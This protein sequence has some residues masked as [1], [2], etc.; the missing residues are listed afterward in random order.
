[1]PKTTK[2][3]RGALRIVEV[4]E[5]SIALTEFFGEEGKKQPKLKMTAY[6]G[7]VIK[8]HWY[9]DDLILDLQGVSFEKKFPILENHSTDRKIAF[10]SSPILENGKLEINPEKTKFVDTEISEEF[11]RLSSEG[12]PYQCSVYANP[13]VVERLS[14][15][16]TAEANGITLKG[17]GTIFRKWEMKEASVCVFGWDSKTQAT[18]FSKEE[19]EVD[20]DEVKIEAKIKPKLI[21]RNKGGDT[22]TIEELLKNNPELVKDIQLAAVKEAEIEFAKKE[23]K[24]TKENEDLKSENEKLND[25][26]LALEK[27]E[28]IREAKEL[29]NTADDIWTKKLSESDV[30]ENMHEKICQYVSYT[31]FTEDGILDVEKFGEAVDAEIKDWV[32]RGATSK[33]IGSGFT[34]KEVDEVEL[35]KDQK[36]VDDDVN[37]LRKKVGADPLKKDE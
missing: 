27:K 26:T 23:A 15:D 10:S 20:M 36:S 16:A 4:G 3:P 7:G 13:T 6:S 11:Q 2:V 18:A 12:F 17:P 28:A 5:G 31:K 21:L 29:K 34:K 35:A 8:N 22:M 19:V 1:M 30:S 25:R 33:V 14:E 24:L 37:M 32:K 9:W